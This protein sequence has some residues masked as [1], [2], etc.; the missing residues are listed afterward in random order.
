MEP[1]KH[2]EYAIRGE[3][4]MTIRNVTMALLITF[5]LGA[6]VALRSHE[7]AQH[8]AIMRRLSTQL[9]QT[10]T[11][12]ADATAQLSDANKKLAFLETSK[13]RVQV[14][15]YALT[16]DF[17][18]DPVFS[19]NAPARRAFAVPKHTLPTGK[20]LNVALS[21]VAER[22][23]HANLNDTLVLISRNRAHHHLA[24]FVDRTAQSETRPVVDILFADAHEARIWGRRSFYAVDI[25]RPESPFQER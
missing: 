12:L 19:N 2:K 1:R 9:E 5:V 21:P 13:A 14:T 11:Q 17:G 24:R 16:D 20:I 15:A 18:P 8:V 6:A 7:N 10:Q 23:L 22:K 25:S 4:A 3:V